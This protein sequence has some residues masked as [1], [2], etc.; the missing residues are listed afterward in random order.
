MKSNCKLV[1]PGTFIACGEGRNYCSE[2][3]RN[4]SFEKSEGTVIKVGD[5]ITDCKEHRVSMITEW[6]KLNA[7]PF[8]IPTKKMDISFPALIIGEELVD[9]TRFWKVLDADGVVGYVSSALKYR[10]NR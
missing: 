7:I 10:I 6:L 8:G 2:E 4:E 3:C 9:D 1:I 5:I